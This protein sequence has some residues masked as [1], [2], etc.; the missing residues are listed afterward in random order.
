MATLYSD[1]Y[2]ITKEE[3]FAVLV[4]D[5]LSYSDNCLSDTSGGFYWYVRLIS[6]SYNRL[7]DTN[8]YLEVLKMPIPIQN[9]DRKKN[10]KGLF[11]FGHT[12]KFNLCYQRL[13][14]YLVVR[15]R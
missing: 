8:F 12:K 6:L 1:A 9:K 13:E 11:T 4:R 10:M 3:G 15:L 7:D 14:V 2:L 5:I